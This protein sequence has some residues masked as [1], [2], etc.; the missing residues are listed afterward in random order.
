MLRQGR[1]A[2]VPVAVA[3]AGGADPDPE[4]AAPV[5]APATDAVRRVSE[6]PSGLSVGREDRVMLGLTSVASKSWEGR[7]RLAAAKPTRAQAAR[8]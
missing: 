2:D 6:E 7:V 4:T 1:P 3:D 5:Q 8:G